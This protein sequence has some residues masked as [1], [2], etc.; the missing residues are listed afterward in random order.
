M[1][2]T[3]TFMRSV[4]VASLLAT[5]AFLGGCEGDDGLD[6]QDGAP[7][8][9]GGQGPEGPPGPPGTVT[10]KPLESCGVCHEINSA[11]D[12]GAAHE[13]AGLATVSN[14]AFAVAANNVDLVVTYNLKIDGVNTT[15]FTAVSRDQRV[16]AAGEYSD[17]GAITAATSTGNGNYR[18]T[19]PGGAAAA[20]ENSRYLFRVDNPA[21]LRVV[22]VEDFPAAPFVDAVSNQACNNC[23]GESGIFQI[24]GA[25]YAQPAGMEACTACHKSD[26]DVATGREFDDPWFAIIHGVHNS[27]NMPSGHYDYD[28]THRFSV[29]YPTYMTNCSVCHDDTGTLAAANQMRVTAANCFSCHESMEGFGEDAF[30]NSAFHLNYD[31]TTNCQTCH[32]NNTAPRFVTAFHNGLTTGNSGVIWDGE[33]TSVT[34]G[35]LVDWQITDIVDDGT[36]LTVTWQASYNGVPVDPCNA[37]AGPDAPVFHADGSGNLQFLYSYFQGDDPILGTAN[38]PGQPAAWP[39]TNAAAN[40]TATCANGV[41]T[42]VFTPD[43][44]AGATRGTLALQGKPRLPHPS[45]T[46][47]MQVRAKTPTLEWVVGSGHDPALA[48]RRE[49]TDTGKCLDCHVGSLYQHGGNRVDNVE[50]CILC[51]NSASN[52]QNVRAGMG[53][54][55]SE[56][57]DGK[58]GQTFEMKSMLHAIH[59]AGVAQRFGD[60]NQA[61]IAIYRNRGIYYWGL[62]EPANWPDPVDDACMRGNTAGQWVYGADRTVTNACQP[63]NF[64]KPTFPRIENDCGACHTDDFDTLLPGQTV[65]MATTL[66]ATAAA[67]VDGDTDWADQSDDVLQGSGAASCTSCHSDGAAKGH[68]Y[69]NGWTPQAFEEG[70]QTIIDATN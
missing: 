65:A 13:L 55:A 52:E 59:T 47:L 17:L 67:D 40:F 61:P 7:G 10:T 24:H 30:E 5:G 48:E 20:A 58:A 31:E 26:Y 22:V 38:A 34:E 33:D 60:I 37:T 8:Q 18:I 44:K 68:A 63:H 15:D 3:S 29:T 66:E 36:E 23:H 39:T 1:S 4:L 62:A 25:S 12:A 35:R 6:G 42:T 14:V 2:I 69:Q 41:A 45:G 54:D 43:R 46:G 51:H 49:I 21:G 50:M 57:Y 56:A 70:R 28:A 53:V 32:N 16:N 27:H 11:F 19:I 9:P 64:H